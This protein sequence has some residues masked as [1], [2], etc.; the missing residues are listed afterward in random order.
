[1]RGGFGGFGMSMDGGKGKGFG[2]FGP[3]GG[4]GMRMMN[5][6]AMLGGEFGGRG[7]GSWGGRSDLSASWR[8]RGGGGS[9]G[10]AYE[11]AG[12]CDALRSAF[13]Q[14]G[15]SAEEDNTEEIVEKIHAAA[16]KISKKYYNEKRCMEKK[17][18][19]ECRAY[20]EEFVETMM[21]SISNSYGDKPWFEKV[22][23][24]GALLML[25]YWTFSN[26]HVT[27]RVLKSELAEFIQTGII[28]WWEEEKMEKAM[29]EAVDKH[30]G[31][32]DAQ[33]KKANGHLKKSY[34]D[35]HYNAPYGETAHDD[36]EVAELQDFVKGWMASFAQ[37]AYAALES[38]LQDST[39]E[40]Q[41][42]CLTAI[43]QHLVSP[44]VAVLPLKLQNCMQ[45]SPWAFV[46]QCATEVITE[47]HQ[48]SA[49][50]AELGV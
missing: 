10:K 12:F 40:G 45:E 18:N 39:P 5:M 34:D 30:A 2:G 46:E 33:K 47:M 17:S 41:A 28:R 3:A 9:E 27:N 21:G 48:P 14:A 42:A 32:T 7:A 19:S 35:A 49:K 6:M 1:M 50:Q 26:G 31:L 44:E 37:K 38:G 23:W 25:S 13:E 43:F 8:R 11:I 22:G 15:V 24:D 36:P 4:K 20:V 29:W 16:H